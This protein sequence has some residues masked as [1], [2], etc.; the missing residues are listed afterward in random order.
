MFKILCPSE[1]SRSYST[2]I[3]QRLTALPAAEPTWSKLV[4]IF[5]LQKEMILLPYE[6]KH[7]PHD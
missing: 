5:F 1:H 3:E 4:I 7:I 6:S 2:S